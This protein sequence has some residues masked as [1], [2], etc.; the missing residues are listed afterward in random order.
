MSILGALVGDAAGAT[1]EFY[2]NGIIT[3]DIALNAMHMPGG[4][5]HRVG[6]GQITDDGELTIT[7]YITLQQYGYDRL[8]LIASKL[9]TAYTKWYDSSPFDIGNTTRTAFMLSK[10]YGKGNITSVD[11]LFHAVKLNNLESESNGALMRA[12]AIAAYFYKTK[13]TLKVALN[14]A[15]LDALLSHPNMICQE[16]NVLYVQACYLLYFNQYHI[17]YTY[18][19]II[20]ISNK[21]VRE[22]LLL[23][24]DMSVDITELDCKYNAGH[25]KYAFVL[26][27]YFLRNMHINYEKAILMTLMK[28]GDTDTNAAIVGGLLGIYH[29]IPKYMSKP[30]LNFDCTKHGNIRSEIYSISQV[31]KNL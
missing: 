27:M 4:G 12:S 3:D 17:D 18:D 14:I 7:L 19:Y 21:D 1:L 2:P 23:W 20:Q 25:I 13:G 16:I 6:K 8:E 29:F 22:T 26:C 9:A 10:E 15:R 24:Y 11:E 5:V 28:G 30:V 31:V